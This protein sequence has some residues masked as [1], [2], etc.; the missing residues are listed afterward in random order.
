MASSRTTATTTTETPAP[1]MSASSAFFEAVIGRRSIYTISAESPIPDEKIE[2]I[3]ANAV[4]HVPSSFN[5]Q[6]GR[7]RLSSPP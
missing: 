7:V 4:K 2:E 6:S 1:I 5:S 3:V